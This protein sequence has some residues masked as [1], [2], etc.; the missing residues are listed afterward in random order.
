MLYSVVVV[1]PQNEQYIHFVFLQVDSDGPSK[2]I[3]EWTNVFLW[4]S[5]NWPTHMG[6]YI[7]LKVQ[8]PPRFLI[9][10]KTSMTSR[11]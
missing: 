3:Q 7:K 5:F 6:L 10:L 11:W 1:K 4:L 8:L 2:Y 9:L